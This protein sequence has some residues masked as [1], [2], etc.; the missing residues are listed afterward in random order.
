VRAAGVDLRIEWTHA[1]DAASP[2]VRARRARAAG[3]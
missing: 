2:C 3:S 1:R